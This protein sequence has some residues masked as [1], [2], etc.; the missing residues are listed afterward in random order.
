MTARIDNLE[1]RLRAAIELHDRAATPGER[2]AARTQALRL[3]E[4]IETL[5]TPPTEPALHAV[6]EPSTPAACDAEPWDFPAVRR[7]AV[8]TLVSVPTVIA[9]AVTHDPVTGLAAAII[10]W[11]VAI[12]LVT[13]FLGP[14]NRCPILGLPCR[15]NC[16]KR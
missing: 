11:V 12:G 14:S 1:R 5:D 4:R 9:W 15:D 3:I 16:P 7:A 8:A 6:A 13:A 2:E 10:A